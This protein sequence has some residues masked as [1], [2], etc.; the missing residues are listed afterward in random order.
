[1]N[2][3]KYWVVEKLYDGNLLLVLWESTSMCDPPPLTASYVEM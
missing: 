2:R 1:M 3:L